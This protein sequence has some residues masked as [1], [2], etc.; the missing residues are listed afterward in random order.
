MHLLAAVLPLLAFASAGHNPPHLRHRRLAHSIQQRDSGISSGAQYARDNAGHI[1]AYNA[2]KRSMRKRGQTCRPR[3]KL[4]EA[5]SASSAP[6]SS[7][8]SASSAAQTSS[9]ATIENQ[10]AW[11]PPSPT[12]APPPP[13]SPSPPPPAPSPP[14]PQQNGNSG[15]AH[16]SGTLSVN[17]GRCGWC[18]SNNDNPNGSQDW[19]N[20][21]LSNGGGWSPPYV[22]LDQLIAKDLN[23][24]GVFAPCAQY[25]DLFR[26]YGGEFGS[27]FPVKLI[28]GE[29]PSDPQ[30][31]LSCLRLS[32]CKS[33]HVTPGPLVVAARR[34][35][36]RSPL[37]TVRVA[38]SELSPDPLEP[39]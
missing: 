18:N 10:N 16:S 1:D 7:A 17:D 34:V 29:N 2:I 23:P 21:G 4:E 33:P 8:S 30:F 27:K 11:T 22:R 14:P 9:S 24:N 37:L 28:S 26:Q 36:C 39:G 19:L 20:C 38:T 6:A 3:Q 32:P 13:P 35:S 25:F 5:V 15:W 12:A 31:P